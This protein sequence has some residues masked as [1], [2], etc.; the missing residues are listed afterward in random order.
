M[1]VY[2]RFIYACEH[3]VHFVGERAHGAVN[4]S[5]WGGRIHAYEGKA[6]LT[7]VESLL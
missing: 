3:G 7:G 5:E 6:L 1:Y 4:V 2:V